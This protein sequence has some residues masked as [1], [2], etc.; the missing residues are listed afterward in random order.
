M[1]GRLRYDAGAIVAEPVDVVDQRVGNRVAGT[2]EQHPA[3]GAVF[4]RAVLNGVVRSREHDAALVR[5]VVKTK[6]WVARRVRHGRDITRR[7]AVEHVAVTAP[8]R[9]DAASG[10]GEISH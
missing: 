4:D 7:D 8:V 1:A 9:G 10:D 2:L 6:V 5:I 3:R